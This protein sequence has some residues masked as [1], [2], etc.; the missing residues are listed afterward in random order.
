MDEKQLDR[1]Y[2]GAWFL[3]TAVVFLP[4]PF[5]HL[6]PISAYWHLE[7]PYQWI[8]YREFAAQMLARGLFP[9]WAPQISCGWPFL[10]FPQ[11]GV[12]CP[13]FLLLSPLA[14]PLAFTLEIW[15]ELFLAG[16]FAYGVLR[17]LKLTPF[18]SFFGV[19]IS[20]GGVP[21]GQIST[22]LVDGRAIPGFLLA[23][24]SV[25]GLAREQRSKLDFLG[26]MAAVALLLASG[27]LEIT[28]WGGTFLAGAG[29]YLAWKKGGWT[30]IGSM[31]VAALLG[32]LLALGP[33]LPLVEFI[34]HTVR[35]GGVSFNLFAEVS[36]EWLS[37]VLALV[38]Y[39][40]SGSKLLAS[41]LYLGWTVL[42]L[43][44]YAVIRLGR[45]TGLA[46]LALVLSSLVAISPIF[47]LRLLYHL[48]LYKNLLTHHHA[49]VIPCFLIP[50]LAAFGLR[51][52]LKD[53]PQ[54]RKVLGV[55]GF[56]A[57]G[58]GGLAALAQDWIRLPGFLVL[59]G[60][61]LV[62]ARRR[63]TATRTVALLA[64]GLA[65]WDVT[66]LAA[67]RK[68]QS[69][70][71]QFALPEV[72]A[73][74]L[75]QPGLLRFWPL[76]RFGYFDPQLHA[77]LG[78]RLD[79]LAQGTA[80]PSLFWRVPSMTMGRLLD[81]VAPGFLR[82]QDGKLDAVNQDLAPA[83]E[84]VTPKTLPLLS[85]MNVGRI[86]SRGLEVRVPGVVLEREAGEYK[87]F[88]NQTALGRAL[89]VREVVPAA[90]AGLEEVASGRVDFS[91][92]A[93]VT[94]DT[95]ADCEA[96]VA[97]ARLELEVFRPGW[98]E[99]QAESGPC[100]SWLALS[101][102]RL[103]G[104]QAR[105]DNRPAPIRPSNYA[106]LGVK[107][108]PGSH[109]LRIFYHPWGARIGLFA[110]LTGLVCLLIPL[111]RRKQQGRV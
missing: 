50:A 107:V 55:L 20:A 49:G 18:Q 106:F 75:E 72:V 38:P 37:L 22:Y 60:V 23:G 1:R 15:L 94:G 6:I 70:A 86:V 83:A 3:W 74:Q 57:L 98:W 12:Y 87:I 100:A 8:P 47:F 104:W 85:M 90:G 82:F 7:N 30:S 13:L 42:I 108:P 68:P 2:L 16:V 103:P 19:L 61:A 63:G 89:L 29:I 34:P 71:E 93:V 99:F 36:S 53:W 81:R 4:R 39:H 101:E 95:L 96:S 21:L 79:P 52:F 48:P 65:F 14:Y 35:A 56:A 45:R 59:G 24:Y 28:I 109:S 69:R 80:T 43:M 9:A 67:L 27:M 40:L 77:N 51:E 58:L 11:T 32:F 73:E 46:L 92:A 62:L 88:R 110:T 31:T 5:F 78:L 10:S 17:R 97:A 66:L 91:R 25:L 84:T 64:L 111:S 76:S 54:S 105:I 102:N 26:L 33:V 41:N 44:V